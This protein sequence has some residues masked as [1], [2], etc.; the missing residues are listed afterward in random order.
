MSRVHQSPASM[1]LVDLAQ[2]PQL[3][4]AQLVKLWIKYIGCP[5]PQVTST[6]LLVRAVAYALQ[7]QHYGGLKR[8]DLRMLHKTSGSGKVEGNK[9]P[10]ETNNKA[11]PTLLPNGG[12]DSA[13]GK[14]IGQVH[15]DGSRA[16]AQPIALRP[17]TR[18]VR[19]W[20]G[21]SHSVEVRADGFGWNSEVYRSLSA[22]ALAIT[23]ARWS[24]NRFFRL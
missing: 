8:Q 11:V 14:S 24:G 3:P 16:K 10:R 23:G 9:A 13:Q 6:L 5:P 15:R 2:L 4:R 12:V 18:L 17:G 21:R 7:E 1:A 22:V 20:Q 19:E